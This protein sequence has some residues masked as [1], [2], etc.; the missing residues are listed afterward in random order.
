MK[1]YNALMLFLLLP[2]ITTAQ[3]S[4][5]TCPAPINLPVNAEGSAFAF[6]PSQTLTAFNSLVSQAPRATTFKNAETEC[7][8][9]LRRKNAEAITACF[10]HC[11]A[12]PNCTPSN[13]APS[14]NTCQGNEPTDC[15]LSQQTVNIGIPTE[16]GIIPST[17][18]SHQFDAWLCTV[19]A[20]STV[21]CSCN[22]L[23]GGN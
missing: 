12:R 18:I 1:R 10:K 22:P 11:T 17:L 14:V 5:P 4:M 8:S 20:S 19:T 2:L 21:T 23:N 3:Q 6:A 9:V 15:T 13:P 16:D 7:T